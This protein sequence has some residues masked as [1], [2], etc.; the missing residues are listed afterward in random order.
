M[1]S[2]YL[3]RRVDGP[4]DPTEPSVVALKIVRQDL[5]DNDH[6][7][8]MFMDEGKLLSRLRHENI[9][10]TLEVGDEGG[11]AYIA[12]ELL[13][14]TTVASVQDALVARSTRMHPAIAAYIAARVADALAYAHELT[15]P[16]G[17]PLSLI[18]RDVNPSNVFVTFEGAVK[19]FDFGMAKMRDRAMQSSPNIVKGKLPYLSPEQVMQLPLDSRSDVFALGTTLW[20]LCTARRLFRRDSDMDTVRAVHVG[21]IPDVREGAPDV[22]DALARIIRKALERNREHRYAT[23]GELAAEL[24]AF[25]AGDAPRPRVASLVTEL[26]PAEAKRQGNWLKPA[27]A[28]PSSRNSRRPPG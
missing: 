2:I 23:A 5:V 16:A 10:R 4:A 28:P 1:S 11:Q 20:E 8:H 12:M 22:P 24:D 9:V 3:G 18:H 15:D 14:G 7:L 25:L 21:P 26:F 19:L 27:V 13:L 17:Q 6:V